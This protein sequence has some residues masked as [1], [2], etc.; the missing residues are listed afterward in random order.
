MPSSIYEYSEYRAFIRDRS[1]ERKSC[2]QRAIAGRLKQSGAHVS[3]VVGG[4]R[5]IPLEDARKWSAAMFLEPEEASYFEALVRM[6][7]SPTDELRRAARMQI[8]A[9]RQYERD[10]KKTG[11]DV[12]KIHTDLTRLTISELTTLAGFRP[13]LEW[14]AARMPGVDLERIRTELDNLMSSGLLKQQKDG[15]WKQVQPMRATGSE[16]SQPDLARQVRQIHLELLDR[17]GQSLQ[18]DPASARHFVAASF[19]IRSSDLPA[20][21]RALHQMEIDAINPFRELQDA[22]QVVALGLFV[23]P[24]SRPVEEGDAG[25]RS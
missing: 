6:E 4:E 23:I 25:P 22:D 20:L 10:R 9:T 1:K 16:V 17:A 21:K 8:D 18:T 7:N 12:R 11:N 2:T 19:S 3:M 14:I 13:D 15:S 5:R 24:L